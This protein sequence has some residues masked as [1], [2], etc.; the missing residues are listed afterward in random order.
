MIFSLVFLRNASACN[1]TAQF[2]KEDAVT[3]RELCLVVNPRMWGASPSDVQLLIVFKQDFT[4][5]Q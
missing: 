4:Y 5:Y 2:F 1:K 3:P